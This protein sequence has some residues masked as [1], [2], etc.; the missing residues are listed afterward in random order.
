MGILNWLFGRR[1]KKKKKLVKIVKPKEGNLKEV[2]A[3]E[4]ERLVVLTSAAALDVPQKTYSPTVEHPLLSIQDR[5]SKLEE[6]YRGLNLKVATKQDASDIKNM[7][8]FNTAKVEGVAGKVKS[9]DEKLDSLQERKR[10]LTR[11]LTHQQEELEEVEEEIGLLDADK[12]ILG[13][14]SEGEV[15]TMEIADKLSFTR[16]Y[17]WARMKEL[18]NSGKVTSVKRGRQTKYSLTY[19]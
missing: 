11:Q 5:I 9:M 6:L 2:S 13:L 18:T 19:R 16:Q 10:Q 7:L 15:S 1:R 8:E 3:G 4:S 12:K 17:V 14:L